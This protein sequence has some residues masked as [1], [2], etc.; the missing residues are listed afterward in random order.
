MNPIFVT[1]PKVH[2][3]IVSS[4]TFEC[5]G[6]EISTQT[7]R[8]KITRILHVDIFAFNSF[9]LNLEINF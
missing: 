7:L 2:A 9:L 3:V 4:D 8:A 5:H 1:E 6:G